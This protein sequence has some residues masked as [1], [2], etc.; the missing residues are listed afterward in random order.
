FRDIKPENV[1]LTEEFKVRLAD[2]G[3]T[4][5][6]Q[7]GRE[8]ITA[9]GGTTRY[10]SPELQKADEPQLNGNSQQFTQEILKKRIQTKEAD[11]WAVG[12]MLYELLARRHPFF[13]DNED[14]IPLG[15]LVH[16]VTTIDPPEIPTHYPE[17]L[18]K[19]IRRMLEKV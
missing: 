1:L 3:L 12:I 10:L 7:E 5:R 14:N 17:S 9:F 15:E 13:T 18:R 4:K 6:L 8:Y 16:R 11:I 19:L 2:F